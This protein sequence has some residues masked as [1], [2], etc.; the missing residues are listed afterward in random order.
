MKD[1]RRQM[2]NVAATLAVIAAY[3]LACLWVWDPKPLR[4][5]SPA[6]IDMISMLGMSL[7]QWMKNCHG[8]RQ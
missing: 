3:G 1:K 5:A 7:A 8:S 6:P 2:V 4:W